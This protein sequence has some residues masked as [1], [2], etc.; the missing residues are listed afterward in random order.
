MYVRP[1]AVDEV[2]LDR[3]CMQSDRAG[4]VC[5]PEAEQVQVLDLV[6]G[7]GRVHLEELLDLERTE[8][9]RRH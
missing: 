7:L 2:Q 5:S 1:Q 8:E 6:P 9:V 3:A 4:L